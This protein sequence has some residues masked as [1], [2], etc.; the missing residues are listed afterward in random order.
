[1]VVHDTKTILYDCFLTTTHKAIE[2]GDKSIIERW[3]QNEGINVNECRGGSAFP[4]HHAVAD[5]TA[6]HWAVYYGQLEIAEL[7]LRNGAGTIYDIVNKNWYK[8]KIY[9]PYHLPVIRHPP[10]PHLSCTTF[11][12]K[13]GGGIY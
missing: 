13:W 4:R 8:D 5:G 9:I 3:L 1:M 7:L 11:S 10:P 12:Q 6:L 2:T